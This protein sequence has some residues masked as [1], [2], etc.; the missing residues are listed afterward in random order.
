MSFIDGATQESL[1]CPGTRLNF[2]FQMGFHYFSTERIKE[3]GESF[4]ACMDIGILFA[5]GVKFVKRR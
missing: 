4:F 3:E 5:T 2:L 1:F